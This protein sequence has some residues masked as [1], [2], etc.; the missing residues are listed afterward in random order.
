MIEMLMVVAIIGILVAVVL[1]QFSKMKENQILKNTVGDI[2]S[3][4]HTAQAQS[5]ASVNSSEY[6][7]HF[8]SDKMILFK[9]KVF[10]SNAVDNKTTNITSP[11]VIS[12]VTINGVSGTSGDIY[13]NRPSGTPSNSGV[14]TVTIS[15]SSYSKIITISPTGTVSVN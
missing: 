11:A 3:V 4:L 8:Q 12:N 9:G 6:G 5:L 10:S 7:V 1:P 2:T 14:N 13:F 15:T